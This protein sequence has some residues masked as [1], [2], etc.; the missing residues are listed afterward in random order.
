MAKKGKEKEIEEIEKEKLG[1]WLKKVKK[2][3]LKK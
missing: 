1:K 3:R 2:K